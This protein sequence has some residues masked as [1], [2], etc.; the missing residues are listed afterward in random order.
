[1]NELALRPSQP[2]QPNNSGLVSL[3]DIMERF[4][5]ANF[6]ALER[7]REAVCSALRLNERDGAHSMSAAL[8]GLLPRDAGRQF[9]QTLIPHIVEDM[10]RICHK[11]QLEHSLRNLEP[12]RF[13]PP[14]TDRELA[15][16]YDMLI[17]EIGDSAFFQMSRERA[18]FYER[19]TLIG[20]EVKNRFIAVP[21]EVKA[22]GTAYSC[23]LPTA[24]VF[25]A[26]RAV[27]VGLLEIAGQL[28]VTTTGEEM[29]KNLVDGIQSAARKLDDVP[30]HPNKKS[31][32][33]F[34][35][36]VALEAGLMKD[37]WRNYAAH[38]KTTYSDRE[39]LDI[40]NATCRFF[41]KI[42]ARDAPAG[43]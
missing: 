14:Q 21:H 40:L 4:Q 10:V 35:S 7:L 43:P 5:L 1:M 32:S 13:N 9:T 23:S 8:L 24:S 33:Q 29:M 37:A 36:D 28:G 15:F 31:D 25:H 34:Y 41:E 30:R 11:F 38:A 3:W 19:N 12:L 27:E 18:S 22:A 6:I 42:A 26:M 2:C 39:A 17:N 20:D 16:S